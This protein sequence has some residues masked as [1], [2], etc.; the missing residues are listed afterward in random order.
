MADC[1]GA[2]RTSLSKAEKQKCKAIARSKGMTLTGFHDAVMR[3]AIR[4][5]KV[6]C[7]ERRSNSVTE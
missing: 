5:Q 4:N 7:T 2:F 6:F 1:Y 3:E